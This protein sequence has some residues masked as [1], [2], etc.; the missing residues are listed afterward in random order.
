VDG[1]IDIDK[2]RELVGNAVLWPRVRDFLW[3]FAPQVHE[4]WLS[5]LTSGWLGS[6]GMQPDISASQPTAQPSS[7]LD[8][9]SPRVKAWLLR[10]LGVE[11]CFHSFPK[12]DG[13]RLLLLDGATLLE[14]EKWLG[15]LACAN[16]LRRITDGATVRSLKAALHGVYPEVFGYTA[17]FKD[18]EKLC[19][20]VAKWF[21]GADGDKKLDD[22][23]VVAVGHA[24]VDDAFAHLSA[25]ILKRFRLKLPK[26]L[27]PRPPLQ[28]PRPSDHLTTRPLNLQLLLKLRFSEAYALCSS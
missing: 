12:D 6:S 27:P 8:T 21:D 19:G 4:S 11:P 25:P 9:G 24:L 13:S 2:A 20:L 14:I 1:V 3:D 18:L 16:V 5:S 15:A 7:G 28:F 17:Y 26:N 22:E 10:E 23:F